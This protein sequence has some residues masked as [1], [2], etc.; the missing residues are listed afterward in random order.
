MFQAK[1]Y[2]NDPS[3]EQFI[4]VSCYVFVFVP[5]IGCAL[6]VGVKGIYVSQIVCKTFVL[7]I[8]SLIF[9]VKGLGK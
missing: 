2:L 6:F 3:L 1:L 4:E 7:T 8:N 5:R 9:T